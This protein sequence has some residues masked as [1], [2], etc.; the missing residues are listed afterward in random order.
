MERYGERERERERESA[1]IKRCVEWDRVDASFR[2]T[3]NEIDANDDGRHLR[4]LS[5]EIE[6]RTYDIRTRL[7]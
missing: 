1:R 6:E 3:E 4:V 7:S 2:D 5:R